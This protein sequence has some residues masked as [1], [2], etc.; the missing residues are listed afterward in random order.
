MA[1][2]IEIIGLEAIPLV[3]PGDDLASLIHRS[4]VE[5]GIPISD[6]DILV[7]TQRVVSK[8][9][10]RLVNLEDVA[11]SSFADKIAA[12]LKKD[13][14]IVELILGEAKSIVR[15]GQGHL[16]TET[17]HGWVCANSG[18]DISNTPLGTA[19]L[20]PVDPDRSARKIRDGIETLTGKRVAVVIS[21]TFGRPFREGQV[22]M[23]IGAAGISAIKDRR[24][25]KDL[26]GYTIRVKQTAIIDEIASAAELVIGQVREGVPVAIVRGYRFMVDENGKA[27]N[28]VRSRSRDL[29][30]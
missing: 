26:Y 20:L 11:T 14:R 2:K 23:A 8:A 13:P 5:Q 15:M 27:R 21:D 6:G 30:L 1:E 4:A 12:D 29:F 17:R 18:V 9:E 22:N 19:T 28:L 10:G 16:I 25:E 7:I 24:G 3:K